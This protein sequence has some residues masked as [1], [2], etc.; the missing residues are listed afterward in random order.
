MEKFINFS[1]LFTS[2]RMWECRG[3]ESQG[4]DDKGRGDDEQSEITSPLLPEPRKGYSLPL[5]L[6]NPNGG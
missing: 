3:W 4:D 2:K 1:I 6:P 5:A